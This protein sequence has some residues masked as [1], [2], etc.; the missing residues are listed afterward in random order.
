MD[1][2][3]R[4]VE[5][6]VLDST[7]V[8]GRQF[9]AYHLGEALGELARTLDLVLHT[10]RRIDANSWACV[11]VGHALQHLNWFWNG[12]R[13]S[14]LT[15][16]NLSDE[17]FV[18]FADFP[19][20]VPLDRSGIIRAT[21]A[22]EMPTSAE[23]HTNAD[24]VTLRKPDGAKRGRKVVFTPTRKHMQLMIGAMSSAMLLITEFLL[25]RT[26]AAGV[27]IFTEKDVVRIKTIYEHVF[28]FWNASRLSPRGNSQLGSHDL[29]RLRQLPQDLVE[30]VMIASRNSRGSGE[31]GTGDNERFH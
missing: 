13:R 17:E 14:N 10:E 30:H 28:L 11:S 6:T 8:A 22:P 18:R 1:K 5:P 31:T 27:P 9:D 24:L 12:Q 29:A 26:L 2:Q 3:S 25:V 16:M 4:K 7:L 20:D 19:D 15:G 23:S 21:A